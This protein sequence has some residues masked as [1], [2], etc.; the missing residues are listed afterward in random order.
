MDERPRLDPGA[1]AFHG[2]A[3]AAVLGIAVFLLYR[4]G[5][6]PEP[7]K[8]VAEDSRLQDAV[9]DIRKWIEEKRAEPES[10]RPQELQAPLPATGRGALLPAEAGHVWRYT[11]TVDPATWRDIA[12]TYRT[13]NEGGRLIAYTDFTHAGG[14]MQFRLGAMQAGDPAHANVRF[15]GFFLHTAYLPYPMQAGQ[16]VTW[17]WPWQGRSGGIKQFEGVAKG[18]ERVSVPLGTFEAVRV[19][20]VIKYIDKGKVAATSR[21]TLWLA[22]QVHGIVKIVREGVAP[23]ESFRRIVAELAEYK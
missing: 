22:P 12:L 2:I 9:T 20:T 6:E 21:E 8:P 7:P 16:R 17:G 4:I 13:P 1:L 19:D 11:V 18:T 23:D 3:I 14:A 10:P 5:S 15:P